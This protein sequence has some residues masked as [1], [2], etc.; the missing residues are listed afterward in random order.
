MPPQGR[1][2]A[3]QEVSCPA[4]GKSGVQRLS[5]PNTVEDE[6]GFYT[7]ESGLTMN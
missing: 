1:R 5:G 2:G 3:N 4:G 6:T 7:D